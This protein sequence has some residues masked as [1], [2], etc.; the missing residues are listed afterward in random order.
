MR[1]TAVFLAAAMAAGA[2]AWLA[3]CGE[4]K[5]EDPRARQIRSLKLTLLHNSKTTDRV[6]AARELGEMGDE[7]AVEPLGK[8]LLDEAPSVRTMA[9]DALVRYGDKALPAL[10]DALSDGKTAPRESAAAGLAKLRP[11]GSNGELARKVDA[12]AV[13]ALVKAMDSNDV[14]VR[15]AVT[16]AMGS[17]PT[18][19]S[20]QA[21]TRA[22]EDPEAGVRQSAILAL[23]RLR[24]PRAAEE[25]LKVLRN[26]M[27][28]SGAASKRPT[29]RDARDKFKAPENGD[30]GADRPKGRNVTNAKTEDRRDVM[31]LAC[32]EALLNLGSAAIE[33][34]CK[35]MAGGDARLAGVALELLGRIGDKKVVPAL[36][37]RLRDAKAAGLHEMV[38]DTLMAMDGNT[39][40]A[41]IAEALEVAMDSPDGGARGTAA[42]HLA[43]QR[44]KQVTPKIVAML[45]SRKLPPLLC[46]ES[47]GRMK[48]PAAVEEL[49]GILKDP[50]DH[51]SGTDKN[52][53]SPDDVK[54][55]CAEA[56]GRI[57]D[58]RGGEPIHAEL[59]AVLAKVDAL[60]PSTQPGKGRRI[61]DDLR[62]A[63]ADCCRALG[64]LQYK[65][66]IPD[67]VRVATME[68]GWPPSHADAAMRALAE[69]PEPEGLEGIKANLRHYDTSTKNTACAS[70]CRFRDPG[71]ARTLV[72]YLRERYV[73]DDMADLRPMAAQGL[74][75]M[76]AVAVEPLLAS[77]N[78]PLATF[79]SSVVLVLARIGEPSLAPLVKKLDD[80]NAVT[81]QAAAWALGN[82][83][84][85]DAVRE[86]RDAAALA[87]M[88][89][90]TKD[91]VPA[92]R[93][94]ALWALGMIGKMEAYETVVGCLKDGE[95]GPRRGAVEALGRLGDKRAV[96]LIAPF[97]DDGEH[98]M[99]QTASAALGRIGDPSAFEPLVKAADAET[100]RLNE[101][102]TRLMKED[103][104]LPTG[105]PNSKKPLIAA[106]LRQLAVHRDVREFFR[107]AM[108][109][110]ENKSKQ[111]A[112]AMP[113]PITFQAEKS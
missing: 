30:K 31:V 60:P 28:A 98:A 54:G 95:P 36:V 4:K 6:A 7:R 78:D 39:P 26:A 18:P 50:K 58:R 77:L 75:D 27:N 65:K 9:V 81:R 73:R 46:I 83:Q 19:E 22:M 94:S 57:G 35:A 109:E 3:G 33:P 69:M 108:E 67:I 107:N 110:I 84:W 48:D 11:T 97:L 43:I 64:Q 13:P 42:M 66:A 34:L 21:L 23:G 103:K 55:A 25:V 87:P 105:R 101:M 92:V 113:V 38:V 24:D 96:P 79:R 111:R 45:K 85:K 80:A 2:A 74:A 44:Q 15:V 40:D 89:A 47:L 51:V 56:L 100:Q 72:A 10:L 14:S 5:Q 76:G 49:I 91:P 41:K 37:E 8:A 112:P 82:D 32:E 102:L 104:L 62:K 71:A 90:R 16:G 53:I 93:Q 61:D 17:F 1:K 86:K 68:C 29:P 106:E 12:A 20:I 88:I 52:A 99:R 59:K 63:M 70:L